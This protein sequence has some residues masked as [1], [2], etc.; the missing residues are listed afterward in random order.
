VVSDHLAAEGLEDPFDHLL[1]SMAAVFTAQAK[2]D[3]FRLAPNRH[4]VENEVHGLVLVGTPVLVLVI[5]QVT[6]DSWMETTV[7][8]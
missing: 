6:K 5:K 7:P 1:P 2:C 4:A 8:L 3:P